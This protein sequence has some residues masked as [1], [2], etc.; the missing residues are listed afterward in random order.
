MG[1]HFRSLLSLVGF[2]LLVSILSTAQSTGV[3]SAEPSSAAANPDY[4]KDGVIV[5]H[6]TTRVVYDGDGTGTREIAAMVRMQ[7]EAGVH[8]FAVLAFPYANANEN[9]ELDYV[10]VRKPDGTVVTTPAN[11]IQDMPAE[12]TRVAPMYSD[13]REKHVTVKALSVGDVLEYMVR[14]R[15]VKPQIPGHFWFEYVFAKGN[16]IEDEE[17]EISVP[18]NKY[19]KVSSPGL[20][21]LV[22]DESVRRIYSWKIT[23][24]QRQHSETLTL[25]GD[26]PQA[27][28]ITTFHSWEEVGHWY[29]ELQW[30]QQ[31]VTPE[32][33]SKAAELTKGLTNDDD[34]IRTLYDFV[35][36]HFHYISLSFGIGRYQPHTADEVL[37]NE[38]GDCKDKHTLLAALLKAAGYD[39]WPALINFSRKIDP[40]MPS[41]GQ[42]DHVV[43]ALSRG[44]AL[45]WMDTTPGVAPF[46]MLL[47]NLRN[48]QALVVPRSRAASLTNTPEQPPFLS[49][50]IFSAEGTLTP[51]G[52]LTAHMRWSVRGDS[53]VL[54]R[55]GFRSV[56]P[57]QWK[58]LVQ[59][60][61]YRSGFVGDVSGVSASTPEDTEKAFE[62]A[63]DYSGKNYSEW[64]SRRITPPLPAFGIEG[65][66]D[67]ERPTNPIVLGAPSEAVYSAKLQLPQGYTPH[68][69]PDNVD[70]TQDFAEY[71]ATYSVEKSVLTA[72]R[73]LVIKKSEVPVTSWD[74]YRKFRK[75]VSD[76]ANHAIDFDY[77]TK[78]EGATEPNPES[79]RKMQEGV[80]AFNRRDIT[81]AQEAFR[82]V[83]QIDPDHRGAHGLLGET[84]LALNNI[85]SGVHELRK[86][87]E[88]YPRAAMS[89]RMLASTFTF[90][91]RDD[92]AI[93]QLRKLVLLDPTDRDAA[94]D[95]SHMLFAA[96]KYSEAVS[97]LE[98]A[99]KFAPDSPNLRLLLGDAYLRT[100][101]KEKGMGALQQAV[102][103][104]ASYETLNRA[105][106]FLADAS[107]GLEQAKEYAEKAVHDLQAASAGATASD[108]GALATTM[109][110]AG[111]WDTLGWVYFRLG[112]L[113]RATHYLRAS[114]SFSQSV[115]GGGH[116]AQLYERLGKHEAA[117]HMCKLALASLG[118]DKDDIDEIRLRYE[119]LTGKKFADLDLRE[120]LRRP[121]GSFAPT[122][123]EELSRMRTVKV[124][125]GAKESASAVFSI[126]FS[127]G[128]VDEV[129][130][131]SGARSLESM[132]TRIATTK[133]NVEFPGESPAKLVRGGILRCGSTG[134]DFVMLLPNSAHAQ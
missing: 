51:E 20:T 19:L 50:V 126:V 118:G 9:V 2:A 122:A 120:S 127:P 69:L 112:D 52:T 116:L 119:H 10:R 67:D 16:N 109:Q 40:D 106:Y 99:V 83:L 28:Q 101:Q 37:A 6:Y 41:P 54:F 4:S 91:H 71:H 32:I 65:H 96:H 111:A 63:Y 44:D 124:E 97:E 61:S 47:A 14:Y 15:T 98:G 21:P 104:D 27:V 72:V 49:S 43:T 25:K 68:P 45:V 38:Y 82:R 58:E 88:L 115:V 8:N 64:E 77:T 26:G 53:E 29:G 94:V 95:L 100:A 57:S 85:D 123:G 56:P 80:D 73:R 55:L 12:V 108:E 87:Q 59:Q 121:D 1:T 33:S 60:I 39:A 79:D 92:E 35:S 132:A 5:E 89:Y 105:A 23:N 24:V 48:K 81:G 34:K 7:A 75:A 125:T 129:R 102:A 117:V 62:F 114:W 78:A 11:N 110:M 130:F 36:S 84:Y 131:V 42:F 3:A 31:T 46:G 76:D 13:L 86:E 30:P 90:L 22:K 103:L 18:R 113:D 134:C 17:L 128:K 133:F 93:E 107:V 74:Q 70:A 66:D